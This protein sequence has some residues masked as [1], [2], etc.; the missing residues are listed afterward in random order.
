MN[1]KETHKHIHKITLNEKKV[2]QFLFDMLQANFI[3]PKAQNA[4][5]A[6]TPMLTENPYAQLK[7]TTQG[8]YDFVHRLQEGEVDEKKIEVRLMECMNQIDNAA[9]VPVS[10]W[11]IAKTLFSIGADALDLNLAIAALSDEET[12]GRAIRLFQ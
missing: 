12:R 8:F 1:Q 2:A 11:D 5:V 6:T 4:A 9:S 3:L 10:V 7:Q